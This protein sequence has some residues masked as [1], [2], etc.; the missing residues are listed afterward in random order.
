MLE[1]MQLWF[2]KHNKINVTFHNG[3]LPKGCMQENIH[4]SFLK[5]N[6]TNETFH[7]DILPK[8]IYAGKYAS[9]IFKAQQE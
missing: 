2:L 4:L 3:F 5:H 7:I 8:R 1:N 6:K 9:M